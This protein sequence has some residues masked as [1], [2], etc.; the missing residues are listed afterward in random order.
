MGVPILR[1]YCSSSDVEPHLAPVRTPAPT[2]IHKTRQL[3]EE[4]LVDAE[5]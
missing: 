4:Q 3:G 1:A 5:K 2:A